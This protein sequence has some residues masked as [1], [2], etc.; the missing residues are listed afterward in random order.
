MLPFAARV[1]QPR[2][3]SHHKK[4]AQK[5]SGNKMDD[6]THHES[7]GNHH[8]NKD[9]E[10]GRELHTSSLQIHHKRSVSIFERLNEMKR[11]ASSSYLDTNDVEPP[12]INASRPLKERFHSVDFY[13]T[14]SF[15]QEED[16]YDDENF[17]IHSVN[18]YG[19]RMKNPV[20]TS[21]QSSRTLQQIQKLR[22]K[23]ETVFSCLCYPIRTI[24]KGIQVKSIIFLILLGIVAS[25]TTLSIDTCIYR[26]EDAH[27]RI[28][29]LTRFYLVNY[30]F[31]AIF[32]VISSLFAAA[33]VHFISQNSAGSGLPEMKSILAGNQME[34]YLTFRTMVGKALGIIAGLGAGLQIGRLGPFVHVSSCIA[35]MLL[36]IRFFRKLKKVSEIHYFYLLV[37]A[38]VTK[39]LLI[40]SVKLKEQI[41]FQ[42]LV[43][44][45]LHLHLVLQ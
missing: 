5:K 3:N 30:I 35:N 19:A 36:K 4:G 42:L 33:C 34:R 2:G 17:L 9:G 38:S 20:T 23:V 24:T 31:Y 25:L 44:Q 37:M 18:G 41:C 7:N 1:D 12:L 26:I 21:V 32:G 43:P 16:E 6:R 28:A 10:E 11:T 39:Y 27:I 8:G 13:S 45:V 15:S 22:S 29:S 40:C 14:L